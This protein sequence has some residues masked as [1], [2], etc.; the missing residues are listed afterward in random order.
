[1]PL[2]ELASAASLEGGLLIKVSLEPV[3]AAPNGLHSAFVEVVGWGATPFSAAVDAAKRSRFGTDR[4]IPGRQIRP[5]FLWLTAL[6][7]A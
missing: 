3:G 4:F 1:M 5:F 2:A 6:D 7:G